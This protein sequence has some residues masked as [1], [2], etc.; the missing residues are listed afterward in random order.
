MA[1]VP[2]AWEE[3]VAAWGCT[4]FSTQEFEIKLRPPQAGVF[5]SPIFTIRFASAIISPRGPRQAPTYL[6]N[7]KYQKRGSRGID[8]GTGTRQWGMGDGTFDRGDHRRRRELVRG[9]RG[10][11]EH[12]R[13]GVSG[14]VDRRCLR[15]GGR[16]PV[17]GIRRLGHTRHPGHD[18]G[19]GNVEHVPHVGVAARAR[20]RRVRSQGPADVLREAPS[21]PRRS[22]VHCTWGR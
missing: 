14:G 7:K 18:G 15:A 3:W 12:E 21:E 4:N 20:A 19:A 11:A 16:G 5:G 22:R 2:A 8:T 1:A 6:I 10:T 13:R 17:G 9:V